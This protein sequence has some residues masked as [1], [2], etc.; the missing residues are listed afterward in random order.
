MRSVVRR[1]SS[2]HRR[3]RPRPE[4]LRVAWRRRC[5]TCSTSPRCSR[6][7]TGRRRPGF[8]CSRT[9]AAAPA[10][11][12][13]PTPIIGPLPANQR[14]DPEKRLVPFPPNGEGEVTVAS[15]RDELTEAQWVA[16]RIVALHDD[17]ARWSEV[18]VLCRTSR[19]FFLLQQ[20]FAER[21]IPVEVVGLAG[22]L[23]L[24][25]VVEVLAYAR[26]ANDAMASV[27]LARILMGPRY[28]VGFKDLAL[29]ARWAKGKNYAVARGGWRRRGHA[30]PVRRGAW[31]TSTRSRACPRTASPGWRSS[32][33]SSPTLRD[34]GAGG[35]WRSSWARS[36]GASASSTSSTPTSTA[37]WR[38]SADAT[39]RRSSSRCT[40]SSRS[41]ASSRCGRSSTTSTRSRRSTR[42]SGNPSSP[43]TR[44]PSR[45]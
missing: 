9:S 39:S 11:S 37:R 21:D 2:R 10:S 1:R 7:A 42:R 23:R 19:L 44:T 13:R 17:G 26:A 35:R 28:R 33:T 20:A 12:A 36:S 38:P 31:S 4:H 27:A 5:P 22:L 43:P 8:R 3:R 40:R 29:V 34:A 6:A 30:V 18:A 25:E 41:R 14:P 15:H 24:P 45:S 32:A 16:D